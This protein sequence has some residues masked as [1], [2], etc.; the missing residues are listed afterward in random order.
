MKLKK[1]G[2]MKIV[3]YRISIRLEN[4]IKKTILKFFFFGILL[5][6]YFSISRLACLF[7]LNCQ[8]CVI[9]LAITGQGCLVFR[10]EFWS[11]VTAL[12]CGMACDKKLC[13]RYDFCMQNI[14]QQAGFMNFICTNIIS[15]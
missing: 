13:K 6:A 5:F 7:E 11:R 12:F 10:F 1:N 15:F 14:C 2:G 4:K 8:V 3:F 9:I